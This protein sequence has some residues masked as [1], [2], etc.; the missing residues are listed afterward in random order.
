MLRKRDKSAGKLRRRVACGEENVVKEADDSCSSLQ[1]R[2]KSA[3]QD[4]RAVK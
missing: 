2:K 3:R 4:A 1:A